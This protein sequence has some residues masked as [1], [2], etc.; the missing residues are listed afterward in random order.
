MEPAMLV[1]GGWDINSQGISLDAANIL[2]YRLDRIGE[3]EARLEELR[4]NRRPQQ[5]PKPW[6]ALS[7]FVQHREKLGGMS[8]PMA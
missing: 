4:G 2:R 1:P 7:Q 3:L 6:D 5:D 8:E